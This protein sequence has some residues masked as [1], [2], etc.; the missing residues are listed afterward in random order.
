MTQSL[1][2]RA[3][4]W[5]WLLLFGGIILIVA[6]TT[7][8]FTGYI[9]LSFLET[10]ALSYMM[11]GS[12]S[13]VNFIIAFAVPVLVGYLLGYLITTYVKS[14]KLDKNTVVQTAALQTAPIQT[15]AFANQQAS[16]V[17]QQIQTEEK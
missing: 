10:Y 4:I 11:W 6:L 14:M 3:P 8:H 16:P 2:K 12:Q 17:L 15:Q 7:L 1:K 5:L 9:N 13:I